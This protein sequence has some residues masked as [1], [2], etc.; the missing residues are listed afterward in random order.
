MYNTRCNFKY[1]Q[2]FPTQYITVFPHNFL[3]KQCQTPYT[4]LT[5]EIFV[6]YKGCVLY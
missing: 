3:N 5:G 4:P 1:F 2:V 6:M